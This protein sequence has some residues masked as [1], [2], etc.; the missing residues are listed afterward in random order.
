MFDATDMV[1][2][3]EHLAGSLLRR[4]R[5]GSLLKAGTAGEVDAY[6]KELVETVAGDGGFIL[7]TGIVVDDARPEN[8]RA[9]MDAGRRYGRAVLIAPR[10]GPTGRAI[11]TPTWLGT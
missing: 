5:P 2:V 11:V 1:A 10:T 9:M 7:G 4:Q 3:R 6:V 8:V